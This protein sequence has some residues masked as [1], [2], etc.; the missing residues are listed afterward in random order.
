MGILT[1]LFSKVHIAV[2]IEETECH[3]LVQVVNGNTIKLQ[4][5]K[6]F[7]LEKDIFSDTMNKYL[8][9][10]QSKYNLVYVSTLLS[11]LNQGASESCTKNQLVKIGVPINNV[12][13]RCINNSWQTYAD[14]EDIA[15]TRKLFDICGI[16]LMYNTFSLMYFYFKKDIKNNV[17]Y[18]LYRK[19]SL[20]LVVY[21]NSSVIFSAFF[22]LH[23]EE[24]G[25]FENAMDHIKDDEDDEEDEIVM[26]VSN[27][28]PKNDEELMFFEDEELDL[29]DLEDTTPKPKA[30]K[31]EEKKPE[32]KQEVVV[33]KDK[34]KQP[35][36]QPQNIE[37]STIKGDRLFNLIKDSL[38][39]FYKNSIYSSE[40]ISRIVLA[41]AQGLPSD[42]IS[43][44]NEEL[45][46]D[47]DH[48]IV[49]LAEVLANISKEE[50]GN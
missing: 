41:D 39:E 38:D 21:K 27:S 12:E 47:V 50:V 29:D 19:T 44:L 20:S 17:L 1:R 23:K 5:T 32:P 26:G 33:K 6:K 30:P 34:S 16:D 22:I 18:I 46:I 4:E 48:K 13:V 3:I 35:I 37:L 24:D 2:Y 40:F 11:G 7:F 14:V 15:Y 25:I 45:M 42:I 9:K 43:Y 31:K 28:K 10:W 36:Q 49:N 8:L